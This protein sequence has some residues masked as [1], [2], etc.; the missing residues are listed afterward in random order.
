MYPGKQ[1]LQY[2]LELRFCT[3]QAF[4]GSCLEDDSSGSCDSATFDWPSCKDDY[5]DAFEQNGKPCAQTSGSVC[6]VCK[7]CFSRGCP[8]SDMW[9]APPP[10]PPPPAAPPT[11]PRDP[12][13]VGQCADENTWFTDAGGWRCSEWDGC[14]TLSHPVHSL[15]HPNTFLA[16]AGPCVRTAG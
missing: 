15:R 4:K 2:L 8:Y 16:F 6:G 3:E 14:A 12:R 9:T 1:W 5:C 13:G 11:P 10:T 7:L